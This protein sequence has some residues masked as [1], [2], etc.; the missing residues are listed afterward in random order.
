MVGIFRICPTRKTV[1][2][3]NTMK[4][5]SATSRQKNKTSEVRKG[6]TCYFSKF[7]SYGS[8]ISDSDCTSDFK[9]N[10]NLVTCLL[11]ILLHVVTF[12]QVSS[13][14]TL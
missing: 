14:C 9:C 8:N 12:P 4:L 2:R 6:K 1:C 11:T 5:R 13:D 10:Y 7:K 3:H